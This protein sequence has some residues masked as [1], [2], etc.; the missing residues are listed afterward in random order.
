MRRRGWIRCALAGAAAV[1]L[2]AGCSS[3]GDTSDKPTREPAAPASAPAA[4]A[5]PTG[6]VSPS[7]PVTALLA[8]PETGVLAVLTDDRK[9]L[10]LIDRGRSPA[11][12]RTIALPVAAASLAAG[13]PGEIL[14]PAPD[15]LLRV[16]AATGAI[17]ELAVDGDARTAAP[18][19]GGGYAVGLADGRVQILDAA[20]TLS[21]TVRGLVSA[22]TVVAVNEQVAALDRRQTLVTELDLDDNRP[23]LMLRTGDG[24]GAMIGDHF[25]RLLVTDTAG[26]ELLVYTVDPLV[27]H[28]RFPVGSSPYALAYDQRSETVW[29]TLTGTNEVVGYDL[30]TGIPEEVGRYPTVRQPDTVTIDSR[31]GD[32][33]VGSGTGDGL[34]RIAA[35][36]RKGQ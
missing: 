30:S 25:G 1:T 19:P 12:E 34:Q 36:Q 24:A 6:E 4:T 11:A 17:T 22:D 33:F 27:L 10:R 2:L 14:A 7:A 23:G 5:T 35:D 9:A 18:R 20:G 16:N 21:H 32:M 13:A 15:R 3:G 26:G 31:S 29:V 8:E 28:Q